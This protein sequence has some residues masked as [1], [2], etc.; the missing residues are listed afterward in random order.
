MPDKGES[1]NYMGL[2]GLN[3]ALGGFVNPDIAI[4]FKIAGSNY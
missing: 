2:G 4:L 1:K 3:L